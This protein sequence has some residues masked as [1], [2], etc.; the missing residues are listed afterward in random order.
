MSNG[1]VQAPGASL[2]EKQPPTSLR[3]G[4]V[5]LWGDVVAAVTNVAPSVGV[6]TTLGASLAASGLVTP[7]IILLVGVTFLFIAIAYDRVNIRHPSAAA[8]AMW[9][10][11]VFTPII[12]LALGI[13][14]MIESIVSNIANTTLFGPYL[15]GIFWPSQAS[16]GFLEWIVSAAG[17]VIVGL[18]AIAG[19]RA[20][21]RF[22]SWVIWFEYAIMLVF[23]GVMLHAE[24]TGLKGTQVPSFSWLSP[25]ASTTGAAGIA[26]SFVLIIFMAAG[27]E[28]AVYL[29]EEQHEARRDPGRAGIISVIFCTIWFL[30]VVM[31]VQGIA[32]VHELINHSANIIAYAAGLVIPTPWAYIVSLAVLSSVMGVTQAQLQVFSRIGYRL[33]KEGLLPS[34]LS[35]LSQARTPWIALTVATVF[36]IILLA[37]YLANGTAANA[38]GLVVGSAGILY[39]VMYVA[40]GLA[41]VW[42]YRRTLRESFGRFIYA[43]LLPTLGVVILLGALIKAIP[44]T[45]IGTLIPSAIFVLIGLPIAYIIKRTTHTAFFESKSE[46]ATD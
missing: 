11:K 6:A 24:F 40:G 10:A 3:A 16:N 44:T 14:I 46:V 25:T 17:T 32:P 5:A 15:L 31:T 37:I 20:A 42:Y 18:I 7:F 45:P 9:I 35:R 26:T 38:L 28:S 22:Q 41:C 1:D 23:I 13:M 2:G 34:A 4:A 30:L 29:A 12:G 33:S 8:Q 43:G 21:I 19:V 36:P 39:I 27:W